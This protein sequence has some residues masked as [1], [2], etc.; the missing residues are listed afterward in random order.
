[1]KQSGLGDALLV[2]G[3]DLSGDIGSLGNV[4][5]G[6]AVQ[7][8]TG[9]DKAAME[10][11][12]LARDGRI[13]FAGFFNPAS[14]RAHERLSALPVGDQVLTYCR[15]TG[16]GS[17]AAC[18]LGKQINY[19]PTRGAD[20]SLTVAVQAQGNGFGLEWGRLATPGLR[21][22]AAP[23]NGAS[24][25]G[26]AASVFGLQ[27]YLHVLAVTGTSVTVKLQQSADDGVG[28]PWADVAGGAFTAASAVGAQR[29]ETARG[30][31]VERYLRVV[32]TGAFTAA[33][34]AVVVVRNQVKV[35]F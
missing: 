28:D 24:L 31:T 17:P 4:G 2:A 14:G 29:I 33:T 30:L 22:D 19:D 25:D 11:I 12:G 20:G 34:F 6:P 9:I 27:A 10:R 7:D 21:T 32:T 5:G 16:F 26:G 13:E 1:M 8:V 18:L 15:G 35:D 23:G 3:Y